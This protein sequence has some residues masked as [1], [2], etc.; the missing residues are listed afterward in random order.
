MSWLVQL[1]FDLDAIKMVPPKESETP[2]SW[3]CSIL[4]MQKDVN[5]EEGPGEG[6]ED[7]HCESESQSW[8]LEQKGRAQLTF[9]SN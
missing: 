9:A 3:S 8:P 2:W 5:R 7:Q 1:A 4:T 6:R